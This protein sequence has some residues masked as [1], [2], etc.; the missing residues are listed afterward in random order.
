MITSRNV[1][2]SLIFSF[3]SQLQIIWQLYLIELLE[4]LLGL[5]LLELPNLIKAFNRVWHTGLFHK[6][7]CYGISGYVFGL[8]LYFLSNRRLQM[9]LDGKSSQKYP[10]NADVPQGSNLGPTC[11][12]LTAMSFL[13]ILSVISL[14]MLM[15]LLKVRPGI[16]F[17]ATNK[18]DFW[19]WIWP[20]RHC[21]QGRK[22][23]DW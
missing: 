1:V 8:S 15:I 12:L 10:V 6:R 5:G 22:W 13:I 11:S 14:S 16:W 19:Y 21:K 17:V 7:K 3:L 23:C 9:I 2:I 18:G 20:T 4:L